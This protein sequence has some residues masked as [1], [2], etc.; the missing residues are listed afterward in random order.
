MNVVSH[1]QRHTQTHSWHSVTHGHSHIQWYSFSLKSIHIHTKNTHTA[2]Y[3]G[4]LRRD[5]AW[6][7]M[8]LS[9]WIY[10]P[11]VVSIFLLLPAIIHPVASCSFKTCSLISPFLI[12]FVVYAQPGLQFRTC[13]S[14]PQPA[15]NPA[16]ELRHS[17]RGCF[18]INGDFPGLQDSNNRFPWGFPLRVSHILCTLCS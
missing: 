6:C 11:I 18:Y 5:T 3:S 8:C 4:F 12:T 14:R 15:D 10:Q 13:I 16:P 9:L 2:I 7:S 1:T 17:L